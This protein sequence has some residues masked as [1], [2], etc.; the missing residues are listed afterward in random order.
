MVCRYAAKVAA[1]GE[2][3]MR[4]YRLCGRLCGVGL[5]LGSTVLLG[6]C[7][8]HSP[9]PAVEAAALP[10]AAPAPTRQAGTKQA[11]ATGHTHT[12]TVRPGQSLGRIAET[13]H[14]SQKAIIT[15]N[16]LVPPYDLKT[17][18]K[19][20]IP[21]GGTVPRGSASAKPPSKTPTTQVAHAATRPPRA[22][23]PNKGTEG[24][25]VIPLD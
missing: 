7:A 3:Q 12:I 17:G 23:K 22:A 20:I 8:D 10:P 18:A 2:K 11:T 1:A 4:P 24:P 21:A 15:A 5:V 9:P 13:Y 14:V 19:L 6:A 25:E 16:N